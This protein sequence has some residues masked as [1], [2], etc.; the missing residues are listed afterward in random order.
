[1]KRVKRRRRGVTLLELLTASAILVVGLVGV[2]ELLIRSA[3]TH[4]QGAQLLSATALANSTLAE[5]SG[6]GFDGLDAGTYTTV[7]TDAVGRTYSQQVTISDVSDGGYPAYAIS[8]RVNWRDVRGKPHT[9][10][11]SSI[12]SRVPGSDGGT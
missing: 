4:R 8:V 5:L 3:D 1:M 6:R 2:I 10:V 12:V 7:D 9:N 11:A